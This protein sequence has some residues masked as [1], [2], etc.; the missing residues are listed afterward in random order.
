MAGDRYTMRVT[1]QIF[2]C[3]W[4]TAEWWRGIDHPFAVFVR[5]KQR[6]EGEAFCNGPMEPGK[7]SSFL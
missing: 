2:Q 1:T 4:R 3:P 5:T 6:V 7:G